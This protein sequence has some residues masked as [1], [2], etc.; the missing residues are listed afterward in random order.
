MDTI[1]EQPKAA[2][3]FDE[4]YTRHYPALV[5][6]IARRGGR[7]AAEDIAAEVFVI[8]WRRREDLPRGDKLPWLYKTAAN[9]LANHGRSQQRASTLHDHLSHQAGAQESATCGEVDERVDIVLEA[10]ATL[11]ERD[12]EILRLAAWEELT[13]GQLGEVLD[14]TRTAAAVRLHRAR[15]RLGTAYELLQLN[16][17]PPDLG[18]RGTRR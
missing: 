6:Y 18:E 11:S 9:L 2:T 4:L 17:P 12:Q 14:C 1:V 16:K 15:R 13:P 8:A 5:R 3:S 7:G 10:L